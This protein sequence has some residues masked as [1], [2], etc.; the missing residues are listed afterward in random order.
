MRKLIIFPFLLTLV[1]AHGMPQSAMSAAAK[2]LTMAAGAGYKKMVTELSSAFTEAHGIEAEQIYGN[3]AQV[4]AQAK[5]SGLVDC[6]IGSKS[7]LENSEL[8]LAALHTVGR[9]KLVAVFAKDVKLKDPLDVVRR[10]ITRVSHPDPKK[11]IYGRAADEFLHN[12]G[13]Y[14]KVKDNLLVV[15]TVPQVSSYVLSKEVDVGFVNLTDALGLEDKIGGILLVDQKYYSPIVIVAG[16]LTTA[17][18]PESLKVFAKF[19]ATEQA[20]KIV[21]KHGL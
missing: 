2:K 5:N 11:A 18:N 4:V 8:D 17:P 13:V 9:G 10:D 15:A 7:F 20:R 6:V 14:K 19:L 16:A 1:M 3:M 21:A 12:A